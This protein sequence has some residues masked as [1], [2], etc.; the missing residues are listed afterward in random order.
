[1]SNSEKGDFYFGVSDKKIYIC[2]FEKG[3]SHFKEDLNFEIPDSL[4]NDLNFKIIIDLLK[5]N[6]RKIEKKLGFYLNSGNISIQSK[7]YQSIL[8]SI[9]N[10]FDEKKLDKKVITNILQSGIQ[11]FYIN[12]KNL[13]IIHIII[14]KYIIDDKIY[15]LFPNNIKFKKIILEVEFICLDKNLINKVKKLFNECKINVIK[16]VSHD[17]A[18]KFLKDHLDDTLCLSAYKVLSGINQSEVYLENSI[19]KKEGIFHKIFNFFD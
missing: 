12:E 4:N 1:M 13:T 7:S 16:I 18:K 9:K 14:N 19:S 10:I 3:K 15:N 6:I 17:Y 2:F 8:F 11:K 5:E